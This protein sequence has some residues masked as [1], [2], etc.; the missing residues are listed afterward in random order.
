[1]AMFHPNIPISAK[2]KMGSTVARREVESQLWCR[3]QS[4]GS[5]G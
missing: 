4:R 2:K 5:L 3:K 1:M